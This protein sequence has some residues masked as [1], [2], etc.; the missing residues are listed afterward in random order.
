MSKFSAGPWTP[1]IKADKAPRRLLLRRPGLRARPPREHEAP[2]IAQPIRY[3]PPRLAGQAR[4]FQIGRNKTRLLSLMSAF[5]VKCWKSTSRA[6]G[7]SNEEPDPRGWCGPG[8]ISRHCRVCITHHRRPPLMTA[9]N[10][11]F[12]AQVRTLGEHSLYL[13]DYARVSLSSYPQRPPKPSS[14]T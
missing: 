3:Q 7:P 8:F 10:P 2:L 13:R 12:S 9:C 4:P 1:G 5:R 6:A 14:A 11:V